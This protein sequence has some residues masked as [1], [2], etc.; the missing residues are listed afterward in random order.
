MSSTNRTPVL[1]GW[2]RFILFGIFPLLTLPFI[3][4][5]ALSAWWLLRLLDG[6]PGGFFKRHPELTVA[7]LVI[8]AGFLFII[9]AR[10]IWEKMRARIS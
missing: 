7:A 4:F 1:S 3:F 5:Y 6:F 10:A 2:K 9:T 8:L